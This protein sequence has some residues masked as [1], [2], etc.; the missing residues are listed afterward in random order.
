MR[1]QRR[2]YMKNRRKYWKKIWEI[3]TKRGKR[4]QNVRRRDSK[5]TIEGKIQEKWRIKQ[6]RARGQYKVEI[7][8]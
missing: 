6:E 2:K 4:E 1:K 5:R 8:D 3:R 7:K